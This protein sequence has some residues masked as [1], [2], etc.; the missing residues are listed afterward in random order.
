MQKQE[1]WVFPAYGVGVG[2]W[3]MISSLPR[4]RLVLNHELGMYSFSIQGHTVFQGPLHLLY[5]RLALSSDGDARRDA[6]GECVG[7]KGA[8]KPEL[9]SPLEPADP[10][11]PPSFRPLPRPPG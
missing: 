3:I 2:L 9:R 7:G 8:G 4:R 10:T 6:R 5:V 11:P 1:T